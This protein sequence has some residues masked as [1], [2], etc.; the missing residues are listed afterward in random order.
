M[1]C[2][3]AVKDIV[4]LTALYE[5]NCCLVMHENKIFLQK[6]IEGTPM[7]RQYIKQHDCSKTN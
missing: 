7:D 3:G 1:F 5:Y 6:T 2:N 4:Y